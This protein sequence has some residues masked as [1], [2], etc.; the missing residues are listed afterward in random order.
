MQVSTQDLKSKLSF[1][2]HEAQVGK[3]IEITSH[4]KVIAHLVGINNSKLPVIDH[5]ISQGFI[6]WQGGKPKGASV[7]LGAYVKTMAD[8]VIE[9]R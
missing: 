4:R 1:Y 7:I 2:L 9:D 3:A 6:S 8:M 5:L